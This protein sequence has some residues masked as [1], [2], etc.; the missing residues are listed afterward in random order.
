[1]QFHPMWLELPPLPGSDGSLQTKL[2]EWG[3]Q[4]VVD[5]FVD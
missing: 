4:I 5:E 2:K 1:M 3:Q